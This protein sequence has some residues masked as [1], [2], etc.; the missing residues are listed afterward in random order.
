MGLINCPGCNTE[1]S[2]KAPA[3]IECGR[4]LIQDPVQKIIEPQ[5][6][7]DSPQTIFIQVPEAPKVHT[8]ELLTR[9]MW[10]ATEAAGLVITVLS[11]LASLWTASASGKVSTTTRILLLGIVLLLAGKVGTWLQNK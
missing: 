1:I 11:L 6:P 5:K 9:N 8:I 7:V 10:K 2:D 3:C 4:P